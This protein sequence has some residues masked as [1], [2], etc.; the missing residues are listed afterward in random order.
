[1]AET[2]LSVR[3]DLGPRSYEIRIRSG[4]SAAAGEFFNPVRQW[5]RALLI[6][7]RAVAQLYAPQVAKSLAASGATV[8]TLVVEPGEPSKCVAQAELLWN[9]LLELGA[10]RKTLVVAVGGG[11]I[12]DLAGFVA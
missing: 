10:D 7:D 8:D 3:V 2:F 6:A 12:G 1:M 9:K 11:V 4:G 5:R